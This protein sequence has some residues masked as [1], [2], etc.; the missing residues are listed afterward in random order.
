MR[1]APGFG[2]VEHVP[3]PGAECVVAEQLVVGGAP[4][5]HR[6]L[7]PFR[8]DFLGSESF[9]DDGAAPEDV[10]PARLLFGTAP[11][12]VKSAQYSLLDALGHRRHRVVVV[13][14]GQVIEDLLAAFVHAAE[15]FGDDDG[16]FVGKGGIEVIRVGIVLASTRLWPS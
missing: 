10:G 9:H 2:R 15:A 16:H 6:D 7:V 13:V 1:L 5:V 8:Q 14:K 11:E 12:L 4:D 3:P